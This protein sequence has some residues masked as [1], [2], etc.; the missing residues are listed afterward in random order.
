MIDGIKAGSSVYFCHENNEKKRCPKCDSL[1]TK[2]KGFTKGSVLTD[3]GK[4]ERSLQRYCC[5]NCGISFTSKGYDT[6]SRVN[7]KIKSKAVNDF[8]LTKN[9]LSEVAARY[10]ISRQS[11]LNWM[12]E[13]AVNYPSPETLSPHIEYS[14]TIQIDGKET[15]VKGERRTIF[16]AVDTVNNVPITYGKYDYEN[17][18]NTNTFLAQLKE[19]YPVTVN[20]ITSDFGRGKCFIKAVKEHFPQVP[21]QICIVHYLRYL[22]MQLPRTRKSKYFWRNN[23]LRWVIKKIV[24]AETRQEADAWL[25]Q[26]IDWIPFFKASYHKRFIKSIIKNYALL[27]TRFEHSYLPVTTNIAEN[28]NRQLERKLK[29]IDGF[30]S[31]DNLDAFLKI[32]F[33]NRKK[34]ICSQTQLT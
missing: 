19:I 2:K 17:S 4:I 29:N 8:V 24:K 3:R 27:T 12:N 28:F 34:K 1:D 33:F 13:I 18:F 20:G 26:F 25:N 16:V 22:W 21:H 31:D 6:R 14:G 32:W 9:S 15:K 10:S 5:K 7:K 11:I 30:K 23:V